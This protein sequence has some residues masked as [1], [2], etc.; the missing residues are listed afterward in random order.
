M[1]AK[2]LQFVQPKF[3]PVGDAC[4]SAWCTYSFWLACC[5]LR[6]QQSSPC[7]LVDSV[8]WGTVAL[9]TICSICCIDLMLKLLVWPPF[10]RPLFLRPPFVRSPFLRPMTM[11]AL[12]HRMILCFHHQKWLETPLLSKKSIQCDLNW[13]QH[14]KNTQQIDLMYTKNHWFEI[15]SQLMAF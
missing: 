8:N 10:V 4:A 9:R 5:T 1:R 12:A 2:H 3:A 15:N 14:T 13:I 6:T 7:E 11:K